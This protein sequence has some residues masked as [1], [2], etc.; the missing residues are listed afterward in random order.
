MGKLNEIISINSGKI[1]NQ[2]R[3]NYKIKHKM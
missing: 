2:R 3:K 1:E